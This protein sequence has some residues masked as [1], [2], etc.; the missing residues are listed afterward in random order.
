MFR[1]IQGSVVVFRDTCLNHRRF[2][3]PTQSY[4]IDK[5]NS[6]SIT[7][8]QTLL[9]KQKKYCIA[10][11]CNSEEQST[12]KFPVDVFHHFKI[13]ES[14]FNHSFNHI[15]F[16][17]MSCFDILILYDVCYVEVKIFFFLNLK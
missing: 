16:H 6:T 8:S 3:M 1:D 7:K 11:S 17:G 10:F 14:D 2:L 5:R 13:Y 9:C 15:I 12:R 4:F